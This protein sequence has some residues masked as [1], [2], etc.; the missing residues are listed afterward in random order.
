MPTCNTSSALLSSVREPT[1]LRLVSLSAAFT[2]M[3]V[4][5]RAGMIPKIIAVRPVT[6]STKAMTRQSIAVACPGAPGRS[7]LP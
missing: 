7:S 5:R 2:L 3:P 1:T 6:A 4:A